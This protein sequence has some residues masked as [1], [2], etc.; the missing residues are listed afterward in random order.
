[1]RHLAGLERRGEGLSQGPVLQYLLGTILVE[2]QDTRFS[3]AGCRCCKLRHPQQLARTRAVSGIQGDSNV[4]QQSAQARGA[5]DFID[6]AAEL[7]C[8]QH[9]WPA[10][11][12][13]VTHA[14][15]LPSRN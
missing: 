13:P 15:K 8:R 6:R 5:H 1:M 7:L 2:G 14:Q 11:R 3:F 9:A 4:G 12:I 10:L